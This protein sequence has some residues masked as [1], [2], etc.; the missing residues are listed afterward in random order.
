MIDADGT[1]FFGLLGAVP[2]AGEVLTVGYLDRP[3]MPTSVVFAPADV[4]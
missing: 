2:Q 3:Q 1:A 4:V